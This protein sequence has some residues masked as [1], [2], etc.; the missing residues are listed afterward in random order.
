[1]NPS[2]YPTNNPIKTVPRASW[3]HP[4]DV[5]QVA[6]DFEGGSGKYIAYPEPEPK[7]VFA[8]HEERE[9][10]WRDGHKTDGPSIPS[11]THEESLKSLRRIVG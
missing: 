2:T 4:R 3:H 9:Y 1:M 11:L 5:W 7:L 10:G 8:G 6:M